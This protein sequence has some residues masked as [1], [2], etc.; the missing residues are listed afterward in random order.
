MQ[1]SGVWVGAH[2]IE[3][4]YERTDENG[5]RLVDELERIGYRGDIP[6]EP[7]EEYEAYLELHIEQGPYLELEGKEVGVVTGVVGFYWGAIT[8]YGE[9]DHSGPTPMHFRNDARSSG[10]PT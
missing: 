4:E 2:D 5:D 9:A 8:Y 10:P 7:Q 3:T 6:A 1:G